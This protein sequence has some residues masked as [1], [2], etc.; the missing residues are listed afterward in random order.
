IKHPE[1]MREMNLARKL[2]LHLAV[3]PTSSSDGH[4]GPL[5]HAIGGEKRGAPR[6]RSEEGSRGVR[7]VVL[8]E[9]DLLQG[10]SERGIDDRLHPELAAQRILH[11]PWKAAPGVREV[12]QRE[13]EN[14]LELEER[15]FVEHHR[16]ELFW[17][18]AALFQTPLDR[19]H[20]KIGITFAPAQP[21]LLHRADWH[22]VDEQRGRRV[23]VMRGDAEDLH[24]YWP[25]RLAGRFLWN[26]PSG[27]RRAARF[28]RTTKG[29]RRTK[30][31]TRRI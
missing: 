13:G 12:S 23:V 31:W 9:E 21:L 3:L 17:S 27:S 10:D 19:G 14:A 30:Y 16:I 11:R 1:R 7:L 5:A 20:R 4:R 6:R 28:A 2:D 29:G 8:G 24:Q 18:Q 22:T 25:R 26:Q 15:F